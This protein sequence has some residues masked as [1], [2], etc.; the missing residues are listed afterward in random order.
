MAKK[1][2]T[3]KK[4]GTRTDQVRAAVEDA[5]EATS[6]RAERTQKAAQERAQE[7]ADELAAVFTR[8]RDAIDDARPVLSGDI[9]ALRAEVNALSDRVAKLEKPAPARRAPARKPAASKV[10][11][12]RAATKR[13]TAAKRTTS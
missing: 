2:D 5:L 3:R 9:D 8:L 7:A 13:T 1:K 10:P 11:A 4:T 12:A 6:A